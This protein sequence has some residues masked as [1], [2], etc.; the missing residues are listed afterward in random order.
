MTE[1]KSI[2][3]TLTERELR[4]LVEMMYLSQWVV[5]AGEEFTDRA[6]RNAVEK[7][8]QK[9]YRHAAEQE[10]TDL[11]MREP[12]DK[13][14]FPTRFLE[15][16][17]KAREALTAHEEENFWEELI[18]RLATISAEREAGSGQWSKLSQENRFRAICIHGDRVRASLNKHG[19]HGVSLVP[20]EPAQ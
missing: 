8:E 16:E 9:I 17:S 4:L 5:C 7:L 3:L 1:K 18:N 15:E 12:G 14:Y 13:Q 2:Q 10:Y 20:A 11:V 19:L 6:Y